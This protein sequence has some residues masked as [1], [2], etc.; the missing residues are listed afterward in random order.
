MKQWLHFYFLQKRLSDISLYGQHSFAQNR[1]R[2]GEFDMKTRNE[3]PSFKQKADSKGQNR[4]DSRLDN[5]KDSRGMKGDMRSD[6]KG[7]MCS[8]SRLDNCTKKNQ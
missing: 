7:D 5:C 6:L 1:V 3:Q 2:G 8:E 4:A